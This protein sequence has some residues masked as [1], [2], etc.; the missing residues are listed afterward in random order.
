MAFVFQIKRRLAG[1]PGPPPLSSM[2][3]G[4]LAFNEVDGTLYY[5]MESVTS[6]LSSVS[7]G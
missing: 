3:G 2:Q 1:D 6:T 5:A 7:G 4:E